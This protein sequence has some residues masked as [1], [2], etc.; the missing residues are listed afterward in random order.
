MNPETQQPRYVMVKV[1]KRW[2]NRCRDCGERITFRRLHPSNKALPFIYNAPPKQ[3]CVR[4][5]ET[6]EWIEALS[7]GDL[8]KH[9]CK[10]R[11]ERLVSR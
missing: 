7:E 6:Q 8:H 3:P 4:D 1:A 2:L 10:G 11:P 9:H 5:E